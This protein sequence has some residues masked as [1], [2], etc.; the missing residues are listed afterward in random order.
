MEIDYKNGLSLELIY[1]QAH[2]LFCNGF[3]YWF[4]KNDI[5][6]INESNEKFR[7]ISSE[8]ELLLQYFM[9]CEKGESDW[10]FSSTELVNFLKTH[11]GK[12][13]SNLSVIQMGKVLNSKGFIRFKQ[14]GIYVYALKERTRE[15]QQI[16]KKK[17]AISY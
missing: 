9:P 5:E 6:E 10:Q 16:E 17:R 3:K 7:I 12:N 8:E 1:S 4:D 13:I 14:H 11:Y 2:F 15:E